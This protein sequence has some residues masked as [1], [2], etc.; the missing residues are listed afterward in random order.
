MEE[1]GQILKQYAGFCGIP[2]AFDLKKPEWRS[3][4]ELLKEI[5]SNKEY[6]AARGSVLNAHYT[7]NGRWR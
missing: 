5:L 3:E 1:D 7:S 6:T 4:T 2:D